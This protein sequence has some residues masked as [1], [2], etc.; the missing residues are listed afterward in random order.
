MNFEE[1]IGSLEPQLKAIAFKISVQYPAFEAD[2]LLQE[3]HLYI[4]KNFIRE[5][6]EFKRSYILQG[7]WFHLKNYIR[8]SKNKFP[9]MSLDSVTCDDENSLGDIVESGEGVYESFEFNDS[10]SQVMDNGL[11]KR[12]KE[13][14]IMVLAGY[15]LREIG[16]KLKVS[17]VM[18][19]KVIKSIRKKA[20]NH[21]F[22]S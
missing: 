19:H 18:V 2:D 10:V 15:T 17:H 7:C 3:A 21:F 9:D 11:S 5:K 4:W 12:E 20:F 6:N 1:L 14:F 22:E 8:V 13:V 16:R